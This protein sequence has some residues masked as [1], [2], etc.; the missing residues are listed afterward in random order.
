MGTGTSSGRSKGEG[1]LLDLSSLPYGTGAVA[2]VCAVL[3]GYLVTVLLTTTWAL[4][5]IDG[6]APTDGLAGLAGWKAVGWL[7]YGAHGVAVRFSTATGVT[8][9]DFVGTSGGSL[10]FL[11]VVPPAVLLLAGALTAV[12][13]STRRPARAAA[14]GATVVVGYA[15]ALLAGSALLGATFDG[16]TAAPGLP[17]FS[18]VGYPLVFGA[19]GGVAAAALSTP[20]A[21]ER[22]NETGN[23]SDG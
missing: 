10:L 7:F 4:D 22:A 5:A 12:R 3:L 19:M 2:G 14:S 15:V 13:V 11:Y 23:S 9:V 1:T 18:A 16:A 21:A 17:L 6:A 20:S 8:S